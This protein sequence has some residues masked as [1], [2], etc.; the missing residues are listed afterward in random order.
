MS[1][2]LS[3]FSNTISV[4]IVS[5]FTFFWIQGSSGYIANTAF[6]PKY[7]INK[8]NKIIQEFQSGM[9]PF[10]QE[11]GILFEPIESIASGQ[12]FYLFGDGFFVKGVKT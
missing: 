1:L 2:I 8:K 4:N 10:L 6:Y 9:I 5:G 7:I 3:P 12:N 11:N